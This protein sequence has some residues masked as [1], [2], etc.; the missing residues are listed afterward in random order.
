MG[1]VKKAFLAVKSHLCQA[2]TLRVPDFNKCFLL[3]CDASVVAISA[4][5]NQ[6]EEGHLAP[7]AYSSRKL[8]ALE[9]RYSI[10]ERESLAVVYGCERYRC[11]LEHKKFVVHTDSEAL[12]W[13]RKRPHQL[14]RIG[15]L[16]LRLS[17]FKF[18]ILHVR[19]TLNVAADALSRMFGSDED[20]EVFEGGS[21][22]AVLTQ[23]PASFQSLR[24][25]Q[26]ADEEC[27]AL[28]GKVRQGDASVRQFQVKGR[29]LVYRTR[30]ARKDRVFVPKQLRHMTMGYYHD[31]EICVHL[32]VTKTWNN[33]K[34]GFYWSGMYNMILK[35]MWRN[36]RFV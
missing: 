12:S 4:I 8:S 18:T 19:G 2:P 34:R 13:L 10:F 7:I 25:H 30:N 31:S 26:D 15:R 5:L 14:G 20:G 23:F 11:F 16:V 36:V 3:Q 6:E 24:S 17:R 28:K 1:R 32:G 22:V 35:S 27:Q 29:L 9:K 21:R 33:V